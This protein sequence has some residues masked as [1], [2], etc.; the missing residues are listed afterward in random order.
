MASKSL[1][2]VPLDDDN[3][4]RQYMWGSTNPSAVVGTSSKLFGQWAVW[5]EK[6]KGMGI[7]GPALRNG[8]F[9]EDGVLQ[10]GLEELKN[11]LSDGASPEDSEFLAGCEMNY[12]KS[13]AESQIGPVSTLFSPQEI[14]EYGLDADEML[15]SN[16]SPDAAIY[17]TSRS[18]KPIALIEAKLRVYADKKMMDLQP[19]EVIPGLPGSGKA[20]YGDPLTDEVLPSDYDQCQWHLKH[21]PMCDRV[22]VFINFNPLL[23]DARPYIVKRDPERIKFLERSIILFNHEHVKTEKEPSQVDTSRYCTWYQKQREILYPEL[24]LASRDTIIKAQEWASKAIAASRMKKDADLC[25]T[26]LIERIGQHEGLDFGELGKLTF[27]QG[28]GGGDRRFVS[29]SFDKKTAARTWE[30]EVING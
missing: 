3:K 26:Q 25:R 15:P 14:K 6:C 17:A 21:Y 7:D 10:S 28:K 16:A 24:A 23:N 5:L 12:L 29:N 13:R 18:R 22:Y 19:N 4:H 20:W 1:K 30:G 27:K 8:K 11:L 9:F 2:I